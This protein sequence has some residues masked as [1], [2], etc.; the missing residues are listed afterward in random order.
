ML[1]YKI[2]SLWTK[3]YLWYWDI[4]Y[5]DLPVDFCTYAKKTIFAILFLPVTLFLRFAFI[6]GVFKIRGRR[7]LG[8]AL[9]R[10][11]IDASK[12]VRGFLTWIIMSFFFSMIYLTIEFCLGHSI[13]IHNQI[14][15]LRE[16]I[17]LLGYA[18]YVL[19][20]IILFIIGL[21]LG[22]ASYDNSQ[23]KSN[24]E[25]IYSSFKNKYCAK[26]NWIKD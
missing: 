5:Y 8:F 18:G 12:N 7:I 26:I 16:F 3:F 9:D 25:E 4:E 19:T 24:L 2:D 23:I 14:V 22:R 10:K 1:N 20:G 6:F 11:S 15:V 13:K 21:T 17:L